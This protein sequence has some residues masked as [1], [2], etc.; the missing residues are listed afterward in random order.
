MKTIINRRSDIMKKR[1]IVLRSCIVTRERLPKNELIRIVRTP[2]GK[3]EI[4]AT[5]KMNGRGAY[6]K[7]DLSVLERAKKSNILSRQLEAEIDDDIYEK[8]EQEING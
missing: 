5:G 2:E 8:I 7:R 6:L 1:K 4:D 3:V